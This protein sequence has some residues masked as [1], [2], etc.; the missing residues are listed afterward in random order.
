MS[1]AKQTNKKTTKHKPK[2]QPTSE[3]VHMGAGYFTDHLVSVWTGSNETTPAYSKEKA[4]ASTP[5]S[6][7]SL[8]QHFQMAEVRR[9][10]QCLLKIERSK[11]LYAHTAGAQSPTGIAEEVLEHAEG[12]L[13]S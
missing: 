4:T 12:D 8:Q 6:S 3:Q 9:G 5:H 10:G 13:Y 11:D 7:A 2:T 1:L